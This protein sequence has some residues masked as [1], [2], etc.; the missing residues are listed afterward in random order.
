MRGEFVTGDFS[1]GVTVYTID[2]T[3]DHEVIDGLANIARS[4]AAQ[5][6]NNGGRVCSAI[7]GQ[8]LKQGTSGW[9]QAT[10]GNPLLGELLV[11]GGEP[12][13]VGL[14]VGASVELDGGQIAGFEGLDGD[15]ALLRGRGYGKHVVYGGGDDGGAAEVALFVVV[16]DDDEGG[17]ALFGDAAQVVEDGLDGE[18][19]VLVAA[20]H[21]VG[22]G[23]DDDQP[24][25]VAEG[26]LGEVF[27]ILLEAE[28]VTTEGDEVK[29]GSGDGTAVAGSSVEA[30][31]EAGEAGFFVD[32]EDGTLL[33]G[34]IEPGLAEGDAEGKIDGEEGPFWSRGCRQGG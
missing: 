34:P 22:K 16:M 15:E 30:L 21:D 6:L 17:L 4:I 26:V 3:G 32:E 23:V 7:V 11:G 19:A 2:E 12:E 1:T 29:R 25:I 27:D 10:R 24:G 8:E 13:E 28:V 5:V 33:D 14:D 31:P 9:A 18:N 20:A